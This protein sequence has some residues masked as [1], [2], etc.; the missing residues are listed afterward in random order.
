M[1]YI[2]DIVLEKQFPAFLGEKAAKVLSQFEDP[3]EQLQQ[4]D[5]LLNRSFHQSLVCH[6]ALRPLRFPDTAQLRNFAWLADINPPDELEL[7]REKAVP[8]TQSEGHEYGIAHPLT[9]AGIALLSEQFPMPVAFS[10]LVKRSKQR[11]TGSGGRQFAGQENEMLDEMFMLYAKGII[12]ARPMDM[13]ELTVNLGE[14]QMDAVARQGI[15][16]GDGHIPTLHHAGIHL[17]S[18]AASVIRY[19]DGSTDREKLLERLLEDFEPGGE[20][21]G[22]VDPDMPRDALASHIDYYLEQLLAM[23]RK[24][25]VLG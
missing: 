6:K 23:F 11:V 17:D 1:D 21:T 15:L 12:H 8:F 9:K 16:R 24:H 5:F 25:G 7:H 13:A 19:L 18:F 22:M 20:L 14:W 4:A 2:C 10:E 3:I